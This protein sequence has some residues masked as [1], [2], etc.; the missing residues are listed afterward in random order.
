MNHTIRER[1][2]LKKL[3]LA[4]Y[5]GDKA[6][7]ETQFGDATVRTAGTGGYVAEI[8]D[9]EIPESFAYGA[10]PAMALLNLGDVLRREQAATQSRKVLPFRSATPVDNCMLCFTPLSAAESFTHDAC[11]TFENNRP[12][13]EAA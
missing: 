11:S 4:V 10:T 8:G 1:L 9:G 3:D 7:V 13:L 6:V 12:D 5:N 2:V